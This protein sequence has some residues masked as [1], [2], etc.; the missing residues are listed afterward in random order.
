VIQ[1]ITPSVG[2]PTADAATVAAL[3]PVSVLFASLLSYN[4][5]QTLLGP[6]ITHLALARAAYLTRHSFFPSL[7]TASFGH[8]LSVAFD[9]AI[10]ACLVA[11]RAARRRAR[12]GASATASPG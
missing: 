1:P 9:F 12:G 4:P 5:V 3:R 10:I 2:V 6:V 11:G 7:I 8:G